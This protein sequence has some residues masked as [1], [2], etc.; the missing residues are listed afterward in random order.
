MAQCPL[1]RKLLALLETCSNLEAKVL[2]ILSHLK[3]RAAPSMLAM[4]RY[5]GLVRGC[6]CFLALWLSYKRFRVFP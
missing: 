4:P 5:I 1:A 3:P 2:Q 6:A